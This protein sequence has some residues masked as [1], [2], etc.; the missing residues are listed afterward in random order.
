M[1]AASAPQRTTDDRQLE[2]LAPLAIVAAVALASWVYVGQGERFHQSNDRTAQTVE[3]FLAVGGFGVILWGLKLWREG[4]PRHEQLLRD[5]VLITIGLCCCFAYTNF[6]RAHFGAFVHTWDTYHYY[7]GAKYFRELGYDKLYE[8]AMVAD[9]E[10][11]RRADVERRVITDLRTNDMVRTNDILAH[12]ER[13]KD[14][15]SEERWREYKS[16]L[17]VFRRWMNDARWADMHKDHGFN[18]TPVWS[19]VPFVLANLGPATQTQIYLLDFLDPLYWILTALI[20]WWAFG[21]RAFAVAAIVLGTNF[22]NRFYWTGGALLRHD[23]MFFLIASIALLKKDRPFLAGSAFAYATLLR[24]FP[25]LAAAGPAMAAAA[26]WAVNR[27]LDQRFLRYVAG[28]AV[29][30]AVLVG[31][32]LAAFGGVPTWKTFIH[33]TQKHAATPLTNH[34]G[35][36]T[37]LSWRPDTT[38]RVLYDATAID[39]WGDWKAGRLKGFDDAKPLFYAICALGLYAMFVALKRYGGEPWMGAAMGTGFIV[40]GA[41]LTCYYYCFL[42]GLALLHEKKREVGLVLTAMCALGIFLEWGPEWR[43][44]NFTTPGMVVF[45]AGLVLAALVPKQRSLGIT[46]AVAGGAMA[47]GVVQN[48]AS[49]MS[50]ELNEYYVTMSLMTVLACFAVWWLF[51]KPGDEASADPEPDAQLR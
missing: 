23:W 20:I 22:A 36:R 46:L 47:V 28:G 11:G 4:R 41:E 21:P 5:R 15:F 26:Y 13:C 6:G 18:G 14:T 35:L 12:P 48:F 2:W 27:K 51:T 49:A 33:N 3:F 16:D 50:Q 17:D 29:T 24:L 34:M 32:S 9:A 7:F 37:V 31:L 10:I 42:M 19:L 8:C 44:G 38:G 43:G 30:T 45:A 1:K 25:G 39:P 40:L